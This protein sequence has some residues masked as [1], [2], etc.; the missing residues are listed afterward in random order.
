MEI[1]SCEENKKIGPCHC[2]QWVVQEQSLMPLSFWLGNRRTGRSCSPI[3]Y[4][5][6]FLLAPP[7]TTTPISYLP[8][9]LLPCLAHWSSGTGRAN[10]PMSFPCLGRHFNN[11]PELK[12]FPVSCAKSA[13][14]S[15]INLPKKRNSSNNPNIL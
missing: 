13:W 1:V 15:L 6:S 2:R 11:D 14:D 7:S 5:F 10:S 12:N 9:P 3:L 8:A 4:H